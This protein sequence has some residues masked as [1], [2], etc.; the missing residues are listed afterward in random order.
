MSSP[1]LH[2]QLARRRTL[3]DDVRTL[4]ERDYL[5]GAHAL[6]V[7]AML[8]GETALAERYGVS[9]VTVRTALQ[10]LQQTGLIAARQGRRAVVLPRSAAIVQGLDRLES[11]ESLARETGVEVGTSALSMRTREAGQAT[12]ARLGISAGDLVL[13]VR[14]VKLLGG[15]R[16]AW[17]EDVMPARHPLADAVRASATGSMVDLLLHDRAAA[18]AYGDAELTP[19]AADRN[20]VRRLGVASRSPIMRV[21][22]T[23]FGLEGD[24]VAI[25]TAWMR[26]SC[27]RFAVR[28]RRAGG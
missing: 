2:P 11:L 5:T 26:P 10:A 12:A 25:S 27:F 23:L 15:L 4:I 1:P 19:V 7:G 28:R 24:A 16:A 20:L 9:R 18:I 8:P 17:V 14:R 21:E 3:S 13:D 22:V 6:D